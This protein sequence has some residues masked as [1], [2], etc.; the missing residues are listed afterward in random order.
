MPEPS[1]LACTFPGREILSS[2]EADE[3]IELPCYA[4]GDPT[5]ELPV[6]TLPQEGTRQTDRSSGPIIV[7]SNLFRD[8]TEPAPRTQPSATK[9]A[10]LPAVQMQPSF[11]ELLRHLTSSRLISALLASNILVCCAIAGLFLGGLW[12]AAETGVIPR[13][14]VPN[15]MKSEP[16]PTQTPEHPKRH[17]APETTNP[18]N[19][20]QPIANSAAAQAGKKS[21]SPTVSDS[22]PASPSTSPSPSTSASA[23]PEPSPSTSQPASSE[24]SAP[25]AEPSTSNPSPTTS[26]PENGPTSPTS[27]T[28]VPSTGETVTANPTTTGATDTA[29]SP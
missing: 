6:V 14:S 2:P 19:N 18:T 16:K 29:V 7:G 8:E 24:T 20:G 10:E 15:I 9:T 17:E 23:Q 25:G 21:S 11:R 4:D 27:G 12:V 1:T 28:T 3:T 13:S 22:A 26:S 5:V